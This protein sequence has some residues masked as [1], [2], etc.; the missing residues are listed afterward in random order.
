MPLVPAKCP[1]CG[2]NVVVDSGKDA[3]VCDF[4]KTP[5]IVEKAIQTFNTTY[6]TTNV[7]N[8]TNN[9]DIK[10]DIVNVYESSVSDFVIK[11]GE[12]VEY[13]GA[14]MD[15]VIPEEIVSISANCFKGT[16]IHSLNI[17]NS[18]KEI[19]RYDGC[20][21]LERIKLPSAVSSG[22]V[23]SFFGCSKLRHID[24]PEGIISIGERA[25]AGCSLLESITLPQSLKRIG[26]YAF[27]ECKTLHSITIPANVSFIGFDAF[28]N[29]NSLTSVVINNVDEIE[30]DLN[31]F[32]NGVPN[33]GGHDVKLVFERMKREENVEQELDNEEKRHELEDYSKKVEASKLESRELAISVFEQRINEY[34]T[35]NLCD[36]KICPMCKKYTLNWRGKCTNDRC[37]SYKR[38]PKE[39]AEQAV[40][41]VKKG[42]C[43]SC[44]RQLK[45]LSA[46]KEYATFVDYSGR[47]RRQDST[48]VSL[49]VECS[50]RPTDCNFFPYMYDICF[51]YGEW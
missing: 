7:N 23:I 16:K 46:I 2:G 18:V 5:F 13:N 40:Q 12:L 19:G 1:E 50:G 3:W 11:A 49:R 48:T 43:P 24:V 15:V 41:R 38:T 30:I 37:D 28:L 47:I 8:V 14:S 39:F 35:R 45:V 6:N 4:C 36:K 26:S 31:A 21:Q 33:H 27:A 29:C 9:N 22:S 17:H 44:N 51:K 32:N 25:F 20:N 34:V 42:R 10:A